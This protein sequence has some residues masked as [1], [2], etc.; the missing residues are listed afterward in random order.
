MKEKERIEYREK[1]DQ[2]NDLHKRLAGVEE[3]YSQFKAKPEDLDLI[4]YA[5]VQ[6]SALLNLLLDS[7][8]EESGI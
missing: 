2:L 4:R 6:T 1:I 7:E 3:D 5:L 8:E